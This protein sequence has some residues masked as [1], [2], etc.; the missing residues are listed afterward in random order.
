MYAILFNVF[1]YISC[2]K[3]YLIEYCNKNLLNQSFLSVSQTFNWS[4]S[5]KENNKNALNNNKLK[6]KKFRI[7]L[8]FFLL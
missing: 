5:A 8:S 7:I 2:L 6:I 4:G 1:I 3:I